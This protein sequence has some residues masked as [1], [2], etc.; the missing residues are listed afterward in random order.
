M[1]MAQRFICG[2]IGNRIYGCGEEINEAPKGSG[3]V[4]ARGKALSDVGEFWSEAD[5]QTVLMHAECG[6]SAGFELA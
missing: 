6:D 4:D 1:I 3:F 2:E 5:D